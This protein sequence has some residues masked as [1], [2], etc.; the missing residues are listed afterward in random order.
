M[1]IDIAPHAAEMG[2]RAAEHGGDLIRHAIDQR[3][4][5]HI[6][7]ATGA[8][9]FEVFAH[10]TARDDIDWSKVVGF[11]LDEY[12]GMPADHPASF[13]R[14]LKERFVD[15]VPLAAFHYLDG[16]A[17]PVSECQRAGRLIAAHPIDVAFIGIGENGHLAFNDPPADFETEEPY[18]FVDLDDACRQQQL[19]EGWFA[20]LD[21]VPRRAISMSIRQIMK[22]AAIVCSVPDA[23]K[24]EAVMA[25]VEGPVTMNLP[26]SILQQHPKAILLLDKAAASL[27]SQPRR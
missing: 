9:Q 6:I 13:C 15:R 25:A 2:R 14:Y 1:Q 7:V 24:A 12:L 16:Q 4:A 10:L 18:I 19:G 8:S 11:H 21:D 3:D 27:L 5:A 20:T 26:A 22:S 23:R 17:D